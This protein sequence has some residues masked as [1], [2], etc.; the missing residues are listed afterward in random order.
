MTRQGSDKFFTRWKEHPPLQIQPLPNI[1]KCFDDRRLIAQVRDLQAELGVTREARNRALVIQNAN[2]NASLSETAND[3]EPLVV[4]A[5]YYGAWD[6]TPVRS[7]LF[8]A[9]EIHG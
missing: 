1:E 7:Q 9:L 6:V 3:S 5:D 4:T 8:H 2:G